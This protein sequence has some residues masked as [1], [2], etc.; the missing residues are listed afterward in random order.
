MNQPVPEIPFDILLVDDDSDFRSMTVRSFRLRGHNVAEAA[1]G[2]EAL[3]QLK[4]SVFDVAVCDLNMPGMSG[5]ELLREIKGRGCDTEVVMLTGAATIQTAVDAMKLGAHDYLTKPAEIDEL[6]VVIG[7]AFEASR[8]KKENR[9]LKELIHRTRPSFN[10]IGESPAM[11]EVFRL[12]ERAAPSDKPIHIYGESGT[13]KELV[14]QALHQASQLADKPI[15]VI[16]CAALPEQLL[17]SELFG[18]EKGAFTGAASAKPGLFEV[19]DGGTMFIDEIGELAGP[20][21]AKLLRVLEDGSLR[22]VGSTTTRKVKTRLL[23]ATN[24]DMLK[25]VK[26]GRFREDLYYRIEVLTL[27]LPALRDRTADIPLLA[28]HFAGEDWAIT[29]DAMSAIQR[30]HWPGNVRQLINAIERAKILAEA[31]VIELKNLPDVVTESTDRLDAES[32]TSLADF[33]SFQKAHIEELLRR[34]KY[35]KA[36]TARALGVSRRTLYRWLEKHG[37]STD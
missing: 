21:Q 30:Y 7:K 22:R 18:H 26:A 13:G 35:N 11:Q 9:Q 32:P 33:A 16:N 24:R 28:T 36:R 14:A 17:E 1:N 12:I 15:V 2:E 19:A 5:V 25:E 34:E 29:P 20:L 27:N 8:L 23:T 4:S 31:D 6:L 10:M 3:E 37:I